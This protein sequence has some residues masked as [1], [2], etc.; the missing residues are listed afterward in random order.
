MMIRMNGS[1]QKHSDAA[2]VKAARD[3]G[4]MCE[5]ISL[6]HDLYRMP[7]RQAMRAQHLKPAAIALI[8]E[9]MN[10]AAQNYLETMKTITR[11][12]G[13]VF[14]NAVADMFFDPIL[15]DCSLTTR[16]KKAIDAKLPEDSL[17]TFLI[18]AYLM[19][20]HLNTLVHNY[21]LF[22]ETYPTKDAHELLEQAGHKLPQLEV[23]IDTF[24][25]E[26][27]LNETQLAAL[28]TQAQK[29]ESDGNNSIALISFDEWEKVL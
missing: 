10:G 28:R 16:F 24:E 9:R 12:A 29:Y 7:L 2:L 22:L 27:K 23:I 14:P 21:T 8:K 1:R 5:D 15:K 13:N 17:E 4:A 26:G 20:M 6:W 11:P 18:S 3:L 25:R 19:R